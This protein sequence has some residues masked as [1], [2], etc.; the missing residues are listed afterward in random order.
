LPRELG[1]KQELGAQV[2]QMVKMMKMVMEIHLGSL[3]TLSSL[4]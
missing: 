1:R 2:L 3:M 4:I